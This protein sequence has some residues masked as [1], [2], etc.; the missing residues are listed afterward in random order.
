MALR[1]M[2]IETLDEELFCYLDYEG[3]TAITKIM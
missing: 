1:L 2:E 3:R